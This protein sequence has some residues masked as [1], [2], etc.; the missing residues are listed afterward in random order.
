VLPVCR[1]GMHE[2]RRRVVDR[3]ELRGEGALGPLPYYLV[4][5]R[6]N[7]L[8]REAERLARPAG[9]AGSAGTACGRVREGE[10]GA[11][12]RAVGGWSEQAAGHRGSLAGTIPTDNRPAADGTA[13]AGPVPTVVRVEQREAHGSGRVLDVVV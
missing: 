10:A 4:L 1:A 3:V 7:R 2:H 12:I 6:E 5:R 9:V 11:G 8:E 13:G